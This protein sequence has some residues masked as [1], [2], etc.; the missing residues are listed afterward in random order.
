MR[1][2]DFILAGPPRTGT[3][4]LD[5]V[6]RGHVGLPAGVKETQFF[7]WNYDL[8]LE[9]YAA[10]FKRCPPALPA[11]EVAPAYFGSHQAR[12]RI[13]RDIPACRIVCTLRDP[14]DRFYS[15]YKMWRKIGLIKAP[16]ESVAATHK[17]L[18]SDT[19]YAFHVKAWRERFGR[20][21]VMVAIHEDS[22]TDRQGYIDRLCRFIG[23]TPIDL[24]AIPWE[25]ERLLNVTRAPRSRKLARNAL[26]LK[27]LLERRG[28]YR[29]AAIYDPIFELCTGGGEE[30]RPLAP[31]FQAQLRERLRPEVEALEE[32]LGRDLSM[33][34]AGSAP[35]APLNRAGRASGV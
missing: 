17:E 15:H 14:V 19:R 9:W 4:W 3:T 12:E 33:W 7:T 10:H 30:Y 24:A 21:N 11:G 26:R 32:L 2:P 16:F 27:D 23:A 25:S 13:A 6:L 18:L 8:G 20:E 31:E 1:L 29:M 22:R 34:K 35:R 28:L 5:R